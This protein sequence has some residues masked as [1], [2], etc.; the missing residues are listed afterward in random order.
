[1]SVCIKHI[2]DG[3]IVVNDYGMI[4]PQTVF[5]KTLITAGK[6]SGRCTPV[7]NS[8]PVGGRLFD[9]AEFT[10]SGENIAAAG[11]VVAQAV[12]FVGPVS[13]ERVALRVQLSS[14]HHIRRT[15]KNRSVPIFRRKKA[16]DY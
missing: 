13:F 1:M 12:E 2:S 6:E 16:I 7:V 11:G 15:V 5:D 10:R 14:F 3:R 9:T 4:I 8:R